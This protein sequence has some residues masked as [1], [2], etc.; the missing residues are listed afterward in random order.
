MTLPFI[1]FYFFF[2]VL[3]GPLQWPMRDAEAPLK[4]EED[5]RKF[6]TQLHLAK[7]ILRLMTFVQEYLTF[8]CL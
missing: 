6:M 1:L 3:D 5:F 2:L 8:I 7:S 4:A